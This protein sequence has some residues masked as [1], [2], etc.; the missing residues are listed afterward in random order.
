MKPMVDAVT[1]GMAAP[2]KG[3]AL[4]HVLLLVRVGGTYARLFE[5]QARHY[6]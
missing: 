6:P 5:M 1:A 3:V 2:D 4:R